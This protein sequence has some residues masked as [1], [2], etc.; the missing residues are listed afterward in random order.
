MSNWDENL[1]MIADTVTLGVA[2][3]E[4]VVFDAEHF[5]DG[6]KSNQEHALACLKTRFRGRGTL[7][8]AVRH[9]RRYPAA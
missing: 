4:E 7:D 3:A 5:F 8:R 6:W 1:R 9:Q 2:R